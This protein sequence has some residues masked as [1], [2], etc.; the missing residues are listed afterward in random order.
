MVPNFGAYADAP[1]G[2]AA[3]LSA[4]LAWAVGTVIVKRTD[5]G[6]MGRGA[7]GLADAGLPAADPGDV[8]LDGTRPQASALA[9]ALSVYIAPLVCSTSR[10]G[11]VG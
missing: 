4:G 5:W 10:W 9:I 1:L 11:R 6:G 3:G 7:D 2:L 8:L